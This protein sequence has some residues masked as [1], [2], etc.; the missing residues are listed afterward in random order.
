MSVSLKTKGP[1]YNTNEKNSS[2]HEYATVFS[3]TK[4][5]PLVN[6]SLAAIPVLLN[7]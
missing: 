5:L 1:Q 4:N 6:K 3:Q 7:H 2:R